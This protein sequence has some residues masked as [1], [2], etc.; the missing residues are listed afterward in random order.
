[1]SPTTVKDIE[2]AIETLTLREVE[3]LVVWLEQRYPQA[4]DGR[5]QTDLEAGSL[6]AAIGR[7]LDDEEKGRTRPL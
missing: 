4:I 1:M 3:E 2:R 6:D 7:A 5:I